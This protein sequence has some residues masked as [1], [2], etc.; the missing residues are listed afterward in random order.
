MTDLSWKASLVPQESTEWTYIVADKPK[1]TGCFHQE[2]LAERRTLKQ[3]TI[4]MVEG[5]FV[6]PVRVVGINLHE[7][8][9]HDFSADV[10]RY[11]ADYSREHGVALPSSAQDFIERYKRYSR[12]TA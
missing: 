1:R 2:V 11:V 5:Q 10:A 6:D 8:R 12:K 7:G 9:A 3:V 4:D